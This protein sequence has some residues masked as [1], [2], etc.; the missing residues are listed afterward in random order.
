MLLDHPDWC[1]RAFRRPICAV[2][3]QK[4]QLSFLWYGGAVQMRRIFPRILTIIL[5]E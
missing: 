5:I 3:D 1:V 2:I 4:V